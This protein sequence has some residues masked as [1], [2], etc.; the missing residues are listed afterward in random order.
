MGDRYEWM[1]KCPNCGALL[2]CYYAES[3]GMTEVKC[4]D[5]KTIFE[6]IL[7]FKLVEK[8]KEK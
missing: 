6:I 4:S 1:A 2:R 3:C 8:K 5:C 7:D